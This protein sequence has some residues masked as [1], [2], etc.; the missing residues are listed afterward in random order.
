MTNAL[1]GIRC[2]APIFLLGAITLFVL[3]WCSLAFAQTATQTW[4]IVEELSAEERVE[5]DFRLDTPRDAH[6]PYLPAET[7]PFSPHTRRK[8]LATCYSNWTLC[9]LASLTYG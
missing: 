8:N 6:L 1:V 9:V 5:L 3:G 7:Y 4:R 2:T